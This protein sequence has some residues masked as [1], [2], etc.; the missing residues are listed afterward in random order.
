MSALTSNE[1]EALAD[2][3]QMMA[4]LRVF[5]AENVLTADASLE[6]HFKAASEFKTLLGHHDNRLSAIAA[7]LARQFLESQHDLIAYDAC[8]RHQNASGLDVKCQ[9]QQGEFII[10]EIKT[11]APSQQGKLGAMQVNTIRKDLARLSTEKADYKYFFVVNEEARREAQRLLQRSHYDQQI[12]VV[13]VG[14]NLDASASSTAS[15]SLILKGND[16]HP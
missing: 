13:N 8:E 12:R 7:T 4:A 10:A 6:A 2:L 3:R 1:Q 5:L 9:T 14:P 15:T 16:P 11:T